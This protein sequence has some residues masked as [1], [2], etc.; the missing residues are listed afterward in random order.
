M[1]PR[2]FVFVLPFD[3]H[4][5]AAYRLGTVCCWYHGATINEAVEGLRTWID[6]NLVCILATD[7]TLHRALATVH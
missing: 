2:G 4:W 5:K 1:I 3:G 7:P 6:A